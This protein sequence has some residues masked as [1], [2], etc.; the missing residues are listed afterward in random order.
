MNRMLNRTGNRVEGISRMPLR[1]FQQAGLSAL[2][3]ERIP[4][5]LDKVVSAIYL[6]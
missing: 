1:A 6:S 5:I 3:R 4:G 2:P